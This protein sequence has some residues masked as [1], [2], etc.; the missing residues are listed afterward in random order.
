L[1]AQYSI[2]IAWTPFGARAFMPSIYT[3]DFTAY[4]P[5]AERNRDGRFAAPIYVGEAVHRGASTGRG[6]ETRTIGTPLFDRLGQ[7]RMSIIQGNKS[8]CRGFFL[9]LSRDARRLDSPWR[10]G[11]DRAIPTPLEYLCTRIRQQEPRRQTADRRA[12]NVGY[13]LSW[14]AV[15]SEYA[16]KSPTRRTNPG[17]NTASA[18]RCACRSIARRR[19]GSGS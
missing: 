11:A 18:R 15:G 10:N 7:H 3:G 1:N 16:A 9:P 8:Q 13:H 6:R 4:R 12:T 19:G 5:L 14:Q 2:W 17:Q